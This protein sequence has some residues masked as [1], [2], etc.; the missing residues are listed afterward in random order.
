MEK[1]IV[2]DIQ[3]TVSNQITNYK[4][5]RATLLNNMISYIHVKDIIKGQ[6]CGVDTVSLPSIE[7]KLS[8]GSYATYFISK[9]TSVY[10]EDEK[11]ALVE[12]SIDKKTLILCSYIS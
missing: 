5:S 3:I 10:Q 12:S 11:G 9:D 8:S 6:V 7:I 4:S 2:Q 1:G